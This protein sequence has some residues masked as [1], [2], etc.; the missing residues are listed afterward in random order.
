[1]TQYALHFKYQ[2]VPHYGI[3]QIHLRRW[4][5]VYQEGGI[6]ALEQPETFAKSPQNPLNSHQNI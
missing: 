2:A 3:S 6:G 5:T 4:I 1:M